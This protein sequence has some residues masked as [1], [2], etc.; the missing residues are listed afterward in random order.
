MPWNVGVRLMVGHHEGAQ[1][2][3]RWRG[4]WCPLRGVLG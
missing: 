2:L 4:L 3:C 1:V